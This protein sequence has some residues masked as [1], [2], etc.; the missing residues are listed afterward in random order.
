MFELQVRRV[1][2]G[3]GLE[4]ISVDAS[5]SPHAAGTSFRLAHR[6]KF[7]GVCAVK[8]ARASARFPCSASMP[9]PWRPA[10]KRWPRKLAA[11][12]SGIGDRICG[13]PHQDARSKRMPAPVELGAIEAVGAERGREVI[14]MDITEYGRGARG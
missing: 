7:T 9:P 11:L 12:S 8:H 1:R 2:S 4:E 14:A 5:A 10:E 13:A 6:Q 3:I